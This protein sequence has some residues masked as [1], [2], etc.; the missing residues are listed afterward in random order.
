MSV[1]K[2]SQR[3]SQRERARERTR[4][5]YGLKHNLVERSGDVTDAGRDNVDEQGKASQPIWIA[6]DAGWLSFAIL[7][8]VGNGGEQGSEQ[9]F[10]IVALDCGTRLWN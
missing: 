4:D 8:K 1:A 3:E 10:S 6:M 5:M 7:P 2:E 9:K